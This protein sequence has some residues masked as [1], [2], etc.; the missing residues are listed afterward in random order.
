LA[1]LDI[2]KK[3]N[4]AAGNLVKLPSFEEV[5]FTSII[6][7]YSFQ[8]STMTVTAF[9]MAGPEVTVGMTGKVGLAGL[10]PL[11]LKVPVQIGR[12]ANPLNMIHLKVGGTIDEPQVGL[13]SAETG[14]QAVDILKSGA[15]DKLLK[16]IGLPTLGG[17]RSNPKESEPADATDKQPSQQQ[18][19][20]QQ[21]P[22]A[23]EQ[24]EG[25]LKGIIKQR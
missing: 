21:Q 5:A 12:D 8:K 7:D 10:Q 15:A 3:L 24:I 13:D 23:R 4:K 17:S 9:K 18:Q 19:P 25:L 11:N 16:S 20:Q 22:N 14:K 6:G 1:P 2:L